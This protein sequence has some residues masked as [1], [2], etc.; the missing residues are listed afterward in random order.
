VGG[1]IAAATKQGTSQSIKCE[2]VVDLFFL[3]EER[4]SS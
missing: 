2:G 1:K 4:R 3:L